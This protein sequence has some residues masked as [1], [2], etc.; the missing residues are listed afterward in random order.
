MAKAT[1][2]QP[3]FRAK[4]Q[5][6]GAIRGW[7]KEIHATAEAKDVRQVVGTLKEA[8]LGPRGKMG[9]LA[10]RATV[11]LD[12]QEPRKFTNLQVQVNGLTKKQAGGGTTVAEVIIAAEVFEAADRHPD[13]RNAVNQLVNLA[14]SAL[15]KSF[16]AGGKGFCIVDVTPP[17]R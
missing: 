14:R 4:I 11:R 9:T 12:R 6:K 3:L 5:A 16:T 2:K 7:R 10:T 17:S 1:P 15:I 8:H 13:R